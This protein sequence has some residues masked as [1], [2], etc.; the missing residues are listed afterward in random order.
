MTEDM[1]F[2]YN[3]KDYVI[4]IDQNELPYGVSFVWEFSYKLFDGTEVVGSNAIKLKDVTKIKDVRLTL[5]TTAGN[6]NYNGYDSSES[7]SVTR[8]EITPKEIKYTVPSNLVYQGDAF[9]NE[10]IESAI[11]ALDYAVGYEVVEGDDFD[12]SVSFN[13]MKL[14]GNYAVSVTSNSNSGNYMVKD[15]VYFTVT[16][17]TAT[18]NFDDIGILEFYYG[19]I[20]KIGSER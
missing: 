15:V 11:G 17:A 13:E 16:H 10:Q 3:G 2:P 4:N 19:E 20:K 7:L 12:Y 6:Y 9:S 18:I 14:P 8:F 5:T 1:E